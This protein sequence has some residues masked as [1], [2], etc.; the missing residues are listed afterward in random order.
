MWRGLF[1]TRSSFKGRQFNRYLSRL[2]HTRGP[3]EH[4]C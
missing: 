2:W 4:W 1:R 3:P